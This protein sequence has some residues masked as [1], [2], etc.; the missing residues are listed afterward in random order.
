MLAASPKGTVPVIVLAS[1]EVLDESLDVAFW[2]LRRNDPENW[3][4]PWE[5]DAAAA[6]ELIARND[7]PFK[8][9]L[10]RYKYASRYEGADAAEHRDEGVKILVDL[11]NR[12]EGSDFL[13]GDAFGF[14]DAAIAPFVRQFRIPA[15][16]WFDAQDWPHLHKW[17]Q[18]F[19]DS[20]RFAIV[21]KKYPLWNR[22]M[23]E[24]VFPEMTG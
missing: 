1:G 4:E 6:D 11:N 5:V 18:T 22:E 3:L 14:L 7:G 15:K 10:D 19:M 13:S 16:E 8:H 21:M 23:D 2:A 20:E 9:H 17:L 24:H 12:L